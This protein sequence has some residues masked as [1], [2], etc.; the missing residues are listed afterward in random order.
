MEKFKVIDV[1]DTSWGM[2]A[3][4]DFFGP[5]NFTIGDKLKNSNGLVW[6]ITGVT[7]VKPVDQSYE[8]LSNSLYTWDCTVE[9]INHSQRLLIAEELSLIKE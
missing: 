9:P 1:F 7:K 5:T 3:V 4:I 2:V 8:N 6:L